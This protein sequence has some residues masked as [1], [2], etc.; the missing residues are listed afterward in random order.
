MILLQLKSKT[1]KQLRAAAVSCGPDAP[2]FG[3]VGL[4]SGLMG[5]LGHAWVGAWHGAWVHDV[6]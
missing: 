2:W 6:G 1:F 5:K 4:G 3:G